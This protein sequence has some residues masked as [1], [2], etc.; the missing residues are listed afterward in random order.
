MR[1]P[2]ALLV[3]T[4]PARVLAETPSAVLVIPAGTGD[5]LGPTAKV[6]Q[7]LAVALQQSGKSA[8]ATYPRGGDASPDPT[9]ETKAADLMGRAAKSFEML[10]LQV[11]REQAGKALELY[12]QLMRAGGSAAG[13]VRAQHLLAAAA[14]FD[15]DN[16]AAQRAMADAI[17]FDER[18]PPK[19]QFNPTVQQLHAQVM[20]QAKEAGRATLELRSE[21][22]GLLWLDGAFRGSADGSVSVRPGQHLVLVF[23]PGHASWTRWLRVDKGQTRAVE[24]QLSPGGPGEPPLVPS[25]RQETLAPTPG[26]AVA[27]A[28]ELLEGRELVVVGA[29][30]GCTP[31]KCTVTLHWAGA[32]RWLRRREASYTGAAG[33]AARALL[34][35]EAPGP[36]PAPSPAPAPSPGPCD[37]EACP[38]ERPRVSI[39]KRWWFW[40]AIGAGLA[41]AAVG[42]AVPL[43]RP[44]TPIIEVR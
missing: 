38:D 9:R 10:D 20:A 42:I 34:S 15:G 35:S 2:L 6:A 11:A 37:G 44:K 3:L 27:Q 12:K 8:R 39:W 36:S 17:L 19:K 29:A 24:A 23:R 43:S 22:A 18:P 25:V 33:A 41:G 40:T 1:A 30:A 16:V 14:L 4:L 21:P 7:E 13:Y 26:R 5:A 32:S 28:L 31:A